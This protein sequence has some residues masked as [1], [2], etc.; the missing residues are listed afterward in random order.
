M[1]MLLHRHFVTEV[2]KSKPVVEEVAETKEEMPKEEPEQA[3]VVEKKK[4]GSS[5][6][7]QIHFRPQEYCT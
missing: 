1:G 4:A 5:A 7:H 3:E 6:L 2:P